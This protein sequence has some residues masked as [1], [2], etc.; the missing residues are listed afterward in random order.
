M[1]K[2]DPMP[3]TGFEKVRSG[4]IT[5]KI[6]K[7]KCD[8]AQP[9]CLRCRTSGRICGGYRAPPLGSFSWTDLLKVRPSTIPSSAPSCTE[10]RSLDFF[11]CIVAP[12]LSSPL[13]NSFWTGPVFQL[14]IQE[15]AT[16]HAVLAIS[17][18]YEQLG[19]FSY[20]SAMSG[21]HGIAVRYYNK[22]LRQVA[23]SAHLDTDTVLLMSILFTCVEFLRGDAIAAIE[24]CRY[25]IYIARSTGQASTDIFAILRHLSIFPFFFGA[26][27]AD[28]PLLPDPEHPSHQI[29]DLSQAAETLDCL[30]SRS[31]RLVR[32]FDPFRLGTVDMAGLPSELTL[33]QNRLCRDLDAWYTSFTTFTRGFESNDQNRSVLSMIEMRWHVC[34][35]WVNIASYQDETLCDEYRSQFERIV[36]LAREDAIYRG[37]S[38]SA[39]PSIFKF[40]MAS[41][42]LLHFVILKCRFLQV[43]L[44]AESL[45]DATLMYAIGRRITEREHAIELLP[46]RG[47]EHTQLDYTLPSDSQRIR[48]SV[49]EDEI[50][51]HVEYGSMRMKRRR[52]AFFIPHDI[53]GQVKISR[54][55][56]H[57]PEEY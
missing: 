51:F 47:L 4:C 25:G 19:S 9:N 27:L 38:A 50:Q 48:D 56:I 23:T 53:Q 37:L 16:R 17:S 31:V 52:I 15:P 14:A 44:E 57:L 2:S 13:G 26:T 30:M 22:A 54:D 20:N 28:F 33:T 3:R 42:P 43:R 29:H 34:R 6:R 35:V 21:Q 10:S 32:A 36:A 39:K 11:R 7:V 5:C 12:A 41:L 18:L 49:L 8:E 55:W 45:W 24:H 40:E 1:V 46:E